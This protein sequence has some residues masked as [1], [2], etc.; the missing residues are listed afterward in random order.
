M[1]YHGGQSQVFYKH[2]VIF[3]MPPPL[4]D[5]GIIFSACLFVHPSV[6]PKHIPENAWRERPAIWHTDVSWPPSELI[7]LWS[8]SIDFLFGA[9]FDLV[10]WVKIWSSRH[11]LTNPLEK[12]SRGS[13]GISYMMLFLMISVLYKHMFSVNPVFSHRWSIMKYG[14]ELDCFTLLLAR[15]LVDVSCFIGL[16]MRAGICMEIHAKIVQKEGET[17][18]WWG[19][20]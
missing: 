6:R 7:R 12:L 11:Y 13:G 19:N 9:F 3:F 17:I 20:S 14:M 10:K 1:I 8:Q 5:G 15:H 18:A 4:G 16:Y 2:C